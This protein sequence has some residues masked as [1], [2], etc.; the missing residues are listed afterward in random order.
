MLQGSNARQEAEQRKQ[1]AAKAAHT[2]RLA[3]ELAARESIEAEIARLQGLE[4]ELQ[5]QLR[6]RESEYR[7]VCSLPTL[8]RG[9]VACM[10]PIRLTSFTLVYLLGH[11]PKVA[12]CCSAACEL[13][14]LWRCAALQNNTDIL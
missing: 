5:D 3:A 11:N 6:D 12:H 9:A 4:V 13:S 2:E 7:Q 14:V 10:R 8:V 1:A